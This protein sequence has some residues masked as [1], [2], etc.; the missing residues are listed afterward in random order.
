MNL[1]EPR[2]IQWTNKSVIGL[3]Q[4]EDPIAV[5]EGKARELVLR[6]RDAGWDGPPFNPLAIADVLAIS[7]EANAEI[8][9][10]RIVSDQS[11]LKIEFNPTQARERVRFSIAHEI[12]HTLFPDVAEEVRHR[13]GNKHVSDDWQLEMLCNIAAAE[14]VMPIGSIPGRERLLPLE[15]LML[16]RHQ[17]DVSAEAFLIRVTKS[18]DEPVI[19]FCA[20]PILADGKLKGYRIDYSV[21]S[22]S[23]PPLYVAGRPVPRESVVSSCI[24]IGYS[25][26]AAEKWFTHPVF[27]ECVGISGYPGSKHPRVAGLLRFNENEAV[28]DSLKFIHGDVLEPRASGTKIICQLVNDRAR[29]WGGGVAKSSARKFPDAQKE[30]SSW[31]MKTPSSARLGGVH[32]SKVADATYLASLVAQKGF[33]SSALPRIRYASLEKCFEQVADFASKHGA[34]IHMP[35]IGS[36]QSGGSWETVEEIARATLVARDIPVT[37]YDLPPKRISNSPG[38]F[39]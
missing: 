14:F 16:E 4:G 22:K 13:G 25:D 9:D 3:A 7:V 8:A 35:K 12:A 19:M 29:F 5:I 39:D 33:G 26:R 10:A 34:S 24:A 17:F 27:L 20:S 6:A 21:A 11:G 36:G 18:T 23:A 1:S 30:Y 31:I 37:V 28:Q 32:I 15:D 38:L 2:G